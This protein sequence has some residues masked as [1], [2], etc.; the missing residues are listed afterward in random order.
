MTNPPLI[1][2]KLTPNQEAALLDALQNGG[3]LFQVPERRKHHPNTLSGLVKAGFLKAEPVGT[4]WTLTESGQT[5]VTQ[6]Y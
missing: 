6:I 1:T 5:A 2:K 3:R 4:V